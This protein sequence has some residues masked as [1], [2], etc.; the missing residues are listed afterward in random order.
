MKQFLL[1]PF[2]SSSSSS[3]TTPQ[4]PPPPPTHPPTTKEEDDNNDTILLYVNGIRHTLK[5]PPP[6]L[7]LIHFLR[8][9][10]RLTGIYIF[11]YKENK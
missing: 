1:S 6:S 7:L 4:P 8:D 11:I 3:T 9:K 2:S 10:L 5:S